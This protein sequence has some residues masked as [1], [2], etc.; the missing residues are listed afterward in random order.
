MRWRL[1]LEEFG[2]SA[3]LDNL[4]TRVVSPLSNLLFPEVGGDSLDSQHGFIVNYGM[5][6]DTDLGFHVDNSEVTLNL[7]IGGDFIGSEVYFQGRRCSEHRQTPHLDE[8]HVVITPE[9]G[10]AIIHAGAHRHGVYPIGRGSR[11][12]LIMWCSSEKYRQSEEVC[13]PWCG[14]FRR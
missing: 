1:I 4:M 9:V 8:E 10:T 12:S 7:C 6:G 13:Q 5:A 2:F 3:Q 14:E 11:R